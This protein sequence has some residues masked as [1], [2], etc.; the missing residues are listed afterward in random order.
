MRIMKVWF[1]DYFTEAHRKPGEGE[2]LAEELRKFGIECQLEL[3]H[4]CSFIFCGSIWKMNLVKEERV[5]HPHIPTIHYNW[6]LYP[7]QLVAR[8]DYKRANPD[9]WDP[10]LEELS[11]CRDIWVPS[12]CTVART[13]EFVGR[14]SSIIKT[15]V[16]PWNNPVE[17]TDGGF[18][19]D[20]MRKYP[21]PNQNA[22]HEACKAVDVDLIETC[23][24]MLW[25]QFQTVISRCRF[26][27]SAQYEA[28]TGGL[29]LLEGLWHGK[30]SLLSDSPRHG[31]I[32][33]F[34]IHSPWV[35]Y[36]TWDNPI[37]LRRKIREMDDNP[38]VVNI[39]EARQ[40]I[41]EMYSERAMA[42]RMADRFWELY[43]AQS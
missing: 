20:V 28:S 8:S 43:D 11:T 19:V 26:M 18:A 36:F 40:F 22:A 34:G 9:L 25:I 29:T 39:D 21:D 5:N 24:E 41:T 13:H 17:I 2:V 12:Q 33:Y 7:F 1:P 35:R 23:N 27:I 37:H 4:D 32:D 3:T 14:S 16:R 30:P 42:K 15:S 38:P 31:A 10:Y 6:D